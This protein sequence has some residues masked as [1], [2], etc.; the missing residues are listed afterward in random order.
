MLGTR[1]IFGCRILGEQGGGYL[2]IHNEL[3]RE[4]ELKHETHLHPDTSNPG[5]ILYSGFPSLCMKQLV[6]SP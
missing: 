6:F 1:S 2:H 3:F 4:P 5:A